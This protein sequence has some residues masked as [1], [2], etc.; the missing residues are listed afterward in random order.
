MEAFSESMRRQFEDRMVKHLLSRFPDQTSSLDQQALRDLT[1]WGIDR[2]ESYEIGFQDDIQRYLEY[3]MVLSTDFDTN[4]NTL[5]AGD[6]LRNKFI[7]GSE[8]IRRI[9]NTYLFPRRG[10]A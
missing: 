1:Q 6:I 2:A 7:E 3:M 4:S 5:W 8:K 9:D 10:R